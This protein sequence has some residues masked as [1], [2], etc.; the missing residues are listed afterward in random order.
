MAQLQGSPGH[1]RLIPN[2]GSIPV[3]LVRE[4]MDH[5]VVFIGVQ[6]IEHS[7]LP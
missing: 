5:Q 2:E 1:G 7:W 6:V 4:S 3:I